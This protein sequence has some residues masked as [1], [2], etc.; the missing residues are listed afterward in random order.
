MARHGPCSIGVAGSIR[1]GVQQAGLCGIVGGVPCGGSRWVL[2]GGEAESIL[3]L[4][5]ARDQRAPARR[6]RNRGG[7]ESTRPVT[8]SE[9]VIAPEAPKTESVSPVAPPTPARRSPVA[10]T[11]ATSSRSA[12]VRPASQSSPSTRDSS[13]ATRDSQPSV[14]VA[15][16]GVRVAGTFC[17]SQRV[18]RHDVGDASERAT[19]GA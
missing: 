9:G 13:P 1:N 19:V 16:A 17:G 8:E 15:R 14:R 3:R 5:S 4:R 2:S 12:R 11:P 6:R 7:P 10:T 18:W